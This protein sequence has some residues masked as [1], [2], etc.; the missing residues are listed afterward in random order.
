ML[1]IADVQTSGNSLAA[2]VALRRPDDDFLVGQRAGFEELLHQL[3]VG[4]GHHFDQ[5]LA[6]R[7]HVAGHL[8]RH[9]RPP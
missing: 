3:F 2:A 7:V 5:G 4:F 8:R 9:W 6:G 1:T